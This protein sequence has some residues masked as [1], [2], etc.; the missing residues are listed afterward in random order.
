[1]VLRLNVPH[2]LLTTT[3][4]SNSAFIITPLAV[5]HTHQS[6]YIA[7]L[8]VSTLFWTFVD[9]LSLKLHSEEQMIW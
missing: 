3:K 8:A 9:E 1:M 6:S 5:D 2:T 4:Y 7:R